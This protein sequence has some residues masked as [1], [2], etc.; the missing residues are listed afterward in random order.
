MNARIP[1]IELAEKLGISSQTV[2]YR[3]NNLLKNGVIQA[4]RVNIDSSKL[5][6][7]TL[8]KLDIYLKD[9]N[10]GGTLSGYLLKEKPFCDTL[11]VATGW[12]DLELE[13]SLK[14]SIILVQIMDELYS[15]FPNSIRKLEYS[16]SRQSP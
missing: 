11:N 9:I 7:S 3:L 2:S 12:C 4:F 5:G 15:R 16:D 8:Y 1:L 14:M 13:L 10:N 6:L